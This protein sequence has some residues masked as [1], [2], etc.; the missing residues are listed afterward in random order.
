MS[1]GEPSL[2]FLETTPLRRRIPAHAGAPGKDSMEKTDPVLRDSHW[3][4]FDCGGGNQRPDGSGATRP[5]GKLD[6]AEVD[7]LKK[8]YEVTKGRKP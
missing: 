7:S 3:S 5:R 8:A 2:Q 6:A 1:G 4:L